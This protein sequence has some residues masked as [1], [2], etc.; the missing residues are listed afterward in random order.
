MLYSVSNIIDSNHTVKGKDIHPVRSPL[1]RFFV[2]VAAA[3]SALILFEAARL[4]LFPQ[5][6]TRETQ[7]AFIIFF[8]IVAFAAAFFE[9]RS[10]RRMR[11]QISIETAKSR[12]LEVELAQLFQELEELNKN[13]ISELARINLDL[14]LE[15][16]LHKQTEEAALASEERFRNMADNL[17]E[18]LTIIEEGVIVYINQ[19]AAKIFSHSSTEPGPNDNLQDWIDPQ[20][21]QRLIELSVEALR[22]Y[23]FPREDEYWVKRDDNTRRCIHNRYSYSNKRGVAR[24]FI[25]SSDITDSVLA[26]QMLEQAVEERTRELSTVLEVSKNITSLL[27]LEP[28]LRVILEQIQSIIPYSGAAIFTLQDEQLEMVADKSPGT[29]G[30][31][32]R[33]YLSLSNAGVYQEVIRQK[34]VL[35]LDDVNGDSPLARALSETS[36]SMERISFAHAHSWIGIPLVVKDRVIGLLSLTHEKPNF[37]TQIHIRLALAIAYQVA[38]AIENARL[39]EQAHDLATIRER[40]RIARELHDSI[41]QL[42]YSICLFSTASARSISESN[43]ELTQEIVAEIKENSLQALREMRLLIYELHPPMLEDTG[44]VVALQTCLDSIQVR[45]GLQTDLT[46]EGIDRLPPSIE[47]EL[48]RVALEALNNLVKY[49]K[50]Q[51]VSIDLRL[52]DGSI[53]MEICDNGLGFNLDAAKDSGGLGLQSMDS[54]IKQIGGILQIESRPGYGTRVKVDVPLH[55]TV[56]ISPDVNSAVEV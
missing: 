39:Y 16:A 49:A 5:S 19:S 55:D 1:L 53:Y 20:E 22:T 42:L 26:Y 44:L 33:L 8:L 25:V 38:V 10:Y 43:L 30:S 24:Y 50:A 35:I 54:R 28:L 7:I 13:K 29:V 47:N 11:R 56:K 48:Y 21:R 15:I 4:L 18:G 31:M 6:T 12:R 34:K 51:K 23:D 14:D 40:Q 37:Y 3:V 27:E 32:S 52:V 41:T 9:I 46:T 17:Q 45:T 36:R 2:I